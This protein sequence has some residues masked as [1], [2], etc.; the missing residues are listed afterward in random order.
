MKEETWSEKQARKVQEVFDSLNL[1]EKCLDLLNAPKEYFARMTGGNRPFPGMMEK[2]ISLNERDKGN[3]CFLDWK[4][5][6]DSLKGK[7]I[8]FVSDFNEKHKE[9]FKEKDLPF[10][11]VHSSFREVTTNFFYSWEEKKALYMW[12]VIEWPAKN[13]W[14]DRLYG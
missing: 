5:N 14:G 10:I 9:E 1:E 7:V 12:L 3:S 4:D 13:S 2:E 6:M 11:Q 8:L